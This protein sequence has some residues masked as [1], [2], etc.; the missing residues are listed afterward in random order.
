MASGIL[1]AFL[2]LVS[3]F[4]FL[5]NISFLAFTVLLK[6]QNYIDNEAKSTVGKK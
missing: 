4:K 2:L 3:S 1:I 6:I 5:T